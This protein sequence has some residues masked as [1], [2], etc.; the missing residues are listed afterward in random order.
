M[1]AVRP[2]QLLDVASGQI[3]FSPTVIIQN[4]RIVEI[5]NSD[6]PSNIPLYNLPNLTLL[7]GLIDSHTHITY[8][9]DSNGRFGW[10]NASPELLF[11]YGLDN[12]QRTLQAGFTTIR[13]VGAMEGVD[14]QLKQLLDHD[15]FRGP[16]LLVSGEPIL[17]PEGAL[18]QV[19]D[20]VNEGVDV[21]K[22]FNDGQFKQ[23]QIRQIVNST[24]LPVSAHSFYPR[25]IIDSSNGGW[26][27]AHTYSFNANPLP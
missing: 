7:P 13:D 5:S 19:Q 22:I 17:R 2:F 11:Q 8:H 20:R 24:R 14:L 1:K 9:F 3:F 12:A 21:I 26:N 16:R 6:P 27:F 10:E 23:E 25:E 4:D 18:Q 15:P